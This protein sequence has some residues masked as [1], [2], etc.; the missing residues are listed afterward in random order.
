MERVLSVKDRE[1][2]EEWEDAL[3]SIN[4]LSFIGGRTCP[5]KKSWNFSKKRKK[6]LKRK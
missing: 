4:A 6:R 3:S 1:R 2:D 5:K